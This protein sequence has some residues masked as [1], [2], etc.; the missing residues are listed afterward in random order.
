MR[1]SLVK[2][3]AF[4]LSSLWFLAFI[5]QLPI[6][7]ILVLTFLPSYA[8]TEAGSIQ[9]RGGLLPNLKGIYW[10]SLPKMT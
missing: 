10:L 5:Q 8:K 7:L 2:R 9:M 4:S 1:F 3:C 6:T